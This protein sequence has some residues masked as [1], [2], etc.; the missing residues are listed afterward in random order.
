MNTLAQTASEV[1][2]SV[3]ELRREG[4]DLI[5][6]T[7]AN[8]G[9]GSDT[10]RVSAVVTW[11]EG[12]RA[13]GESFPTGAGE[14]VNTTLRVPIEGIPTERVDIHVTINNMGGGDDSQVFNDYDLT[15][16]PKTGSMNFDPGVLAGGGILVALL[17]LLR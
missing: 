5:V 16:A 1:S 14:E 15:Q 6:E 2:I 10:T 9:A 13:M 4:D 8:T 17:I 12:T 11:S 7:V 3:S